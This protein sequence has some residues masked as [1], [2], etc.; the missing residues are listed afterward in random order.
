MK[1]RCVKKRKHD[2]KQHSIII[3]TIPLREKG[4]E[5][6]R[7]RRNWETCWLVEERQAKKEGDGKGMMRERIRVNDFVS[8]SPWDFKYSL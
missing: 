1:L 5:I 8:L 4:R 6:R 2:A 7:K 3:T